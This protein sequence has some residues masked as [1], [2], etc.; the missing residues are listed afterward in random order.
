MGRRICVAALFRDNPWRTGSAVLAGIVYSVQ[1]LSLPPDSTPVLRPTS[2]QALMEP[3]FYRRPTT[4]AF[5]SKR[6]AIVV[7]ISSKDASNSPQRVVIES[8][9]MRV[10]PFPAVGT[11]APFFADASARNLMAI[12]NV[13]FSADGEPVV[14]IYTE[15]SGAYWA[16]QEAPFQWNGSQWTPALPNYAGTMPQNVWVAAADSRGGLGYVGD[17][18]YLDPASLQNARGDNLFNIAMSYRGQRAMVLGDG[19]ITA[20]SG[21]RT[22]GYDNGYFPGGNGS[23]PVRSIEW[24]GYTRSVLGAGIAWSVNVQ[25]DVVGDD[26]KSLNSVGV[27]M[28]WRSGRTI[29]LSDIEGTAFGVADDGTIVG[30]VKARAFVIRPNDPSRRLIFLD[31]LVSVGWRISAAYYIADDGDILALAAKNGG[32]PRLVLLHALHHSASVSSSYG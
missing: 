28:L 10:L 30:S 21:D 5:D 23:S 12:R 22:V 11:L 8:D 4:I 13:V 19:T 17:Y 9:G 6:V 2:T 20:L 29:R 14:A 32:P 26:R 18:L 15:L 27:P 24:T 1:I 25:G 16:V 31:D 3:A 7:Q